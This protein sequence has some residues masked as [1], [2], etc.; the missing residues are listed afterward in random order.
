MLL[1]MIGILVCPCRTYQEQRF[2]QDRL[3]L[4]PDLPSLQEKSLLEV[5][6]D[7]GLM[8][9]KKRQC[10]RTKVNCNMTSQA[11]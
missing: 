7:R 4:K 9:R 10:I 2:C 5:E 11:I 1:L 6:D 8:T 3:R